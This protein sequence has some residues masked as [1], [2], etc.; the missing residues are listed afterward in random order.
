MA[1]DIKPK[2]ILIVDDDVKMRL[3]LK[4][5]LSAHLYQI[6]EASHGREALDLIHRQPVDLLITDRDMPLMN[7][8]DLLQKLREEKRN[9]PAVVISGYGDEAMWAQAIGLGAEDYILKPFTSESVMKVVKKKL[10]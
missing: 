8:F 4:E 2:T 1:N 5:I 10:A 3:L 6:L 9:I 7:G